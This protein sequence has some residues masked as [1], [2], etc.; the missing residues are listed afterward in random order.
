M[1]I[2]LIVALAVFALSAIVGYRKGFLKT[3]FA[4]VSWVIVLIVCQIATPVVTEALVANTEIEVIVQET[5]EKEMLEA[6]E[7]AVDGTDI[8]EFEATLPAELKELIL[9]DHESFEELLLDS[10]N[11]DV[12]PLVN[13]II[14]MLGFVVTAIAVKI[15][16]VVVGATLGIISKLPIIGPMDKLLGLACGA[17]QGIIWVWVILAVVSVLSFTGTNT[18]LATYVAESELLTWLQDNNVLLNLIMN[19]K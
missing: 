14:G 6:L 8:S 13:G 4:L 16:L 7:Q 9:G 1:N 19:M 2:L 12:T 18:E 17:G 3:V 5:V 10:A 11:L 15:A